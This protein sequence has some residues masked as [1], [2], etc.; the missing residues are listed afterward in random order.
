MVDSDSG[1]YRL[2]RELFRPRGALA[3]V[4]HEGKLLMI[5]RADTVNRAA[6]M[7]GLPGGEV[8]KGETPEQCAIREL[9]EEVNLV[10]ESINVLGRS[11]SYNGEYDLTWVEIEV[12]DVSTLRPNTREVS[13]IRWLEPG[14]VSGLNP[15][16]P[17]ALEGFARFLGSDWT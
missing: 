8:E 3:V 17:G 15:L 2:R 5:R 13:I 7:W 12:D 11:D 6:G 14:A 4:R 1:A 10:G 16:I 9:K